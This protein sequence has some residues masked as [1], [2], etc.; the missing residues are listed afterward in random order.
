MLFSH[1]E[2]FRNTSSLS[3]TQTHAKKPVMG[4][5]KDSKIFVLG[6]NINVLPQ[7]AGPVIKMFRP[8]PLP[9]SNSTLRASKKSAFSSIS[10][11]H[12]SHC[13]SPMQRLSKDFSRVSILFVNCHNI[14]CF[15]FSAFIQILQI[16]NST[17]VFVDLLMQ[18]SYNSVL[19][20]FFRAFA[21]SRNCSLFERFLH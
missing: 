1:L 16:I 3:S 12:V 6:F 15:S 17:S 8:F 7:F 9:L 14:V 20:F 21:S 5:Q 13:P 18:N 4:L 2:S 19:P 11:T 10:S